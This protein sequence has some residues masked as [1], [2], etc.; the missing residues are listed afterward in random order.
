MSNLPFQ[1]GYTIAI[2]MQSKSTMEFNLKE[3]FTYQKI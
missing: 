1:V 2:M 3:M